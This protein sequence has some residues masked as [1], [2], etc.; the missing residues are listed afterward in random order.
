MNNKYINIYNSLVNLTR[1]K[2]LYEG[3]IK[4]DTFSDRMIFFLFHFAFLLKV[5]KNE[6]S[7]KILQDV[8]DY[9]FKQLELNIRETGYGDV[10]VNKNMKNYINLFYNILESA[11]KWEK[12]NK[13]DRHK[14]CLKYLN[15]S[16]NNVKIM[17]YFENYLN[18][19]K[20]NTFNSLLKGVIKLNF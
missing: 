19:L 7:K 11:E 5:Y 2:T 10:S 18:Y 15:L 3:F 20:N 4:Q 8:F 13:N 16:N 14:F 9:I 1:N 17:N 12:L 6:C